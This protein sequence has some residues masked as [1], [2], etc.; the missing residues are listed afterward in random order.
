MLIFKCMDKRKL[1]LLKFLLNNCGEGY[2][3]LDT[4]KIM[5]VFKKYKNN[6]SSLERDVDY[7]KQMNY[8]DLKYIDEQS[9]CLAIKDNSRILQENLKVNRSSKKEYLL[10]MILTMLLSGMMAFMGGFLAKIILG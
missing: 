5:D 1:L 3:V 2:K 7:L 9:L 10:L 8:I 6:Y 4:T